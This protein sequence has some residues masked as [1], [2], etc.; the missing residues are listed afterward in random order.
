MYS[1]HIEPDNGAWNLT[2][3]WEEPDGELMKDEKLFFSE[4]SAREFANNHERL[5]ILKWLKRYV[6]HARILSETGNKTFYNTQNKWNSLE[7]MI[8]YEQVASHDN[9]HALCFS[10]LNYEQ[11]LRAILPAP[12][13]PSY[14]KQKNNLEHIL[15]ECRRVRRIRLRQIA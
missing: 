13:N 4:T 10:L 14:M 9:L 8:A 3:Q 15:S 6:N 5:F 7:R 12:T 2:L 11:S 1:Y